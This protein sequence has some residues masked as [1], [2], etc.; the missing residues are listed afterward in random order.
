MNRDRLKEILQFRLNNYFV[1]DDL[2]TLL[3]KPAFGLPEMLN[4]LI[5]S[6]GKKV[7]TIDWFR[8]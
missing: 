7:I 8:G 1:W 3:Y 6:F 5:N 4:G 2:Q